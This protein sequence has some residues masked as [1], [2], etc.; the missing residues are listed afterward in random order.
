MHKISI[1][2]FHLIERMINI[3]S[4][5]MK[6]ILIIRSVVITNYFEIFYYKDEVFYSNI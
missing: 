5:N 4:I 2:K 6:L 3:N 1:I